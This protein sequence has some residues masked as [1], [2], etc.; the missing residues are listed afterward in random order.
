MHRRVE[1]WYY[2]RSSTVGLV[3]HRSGRFVLSLRYCTTLD[4]KSWKLEARPREEFGNA[5][6]DDGKG[7][8]DLRHTCGQ[9]TAI[10]RH[11]HG[12]ERNGYGK[13]SRRADCSRQ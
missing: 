4:G 3:R 6:A 2:A 12:T 10:P 5:A 9:P 1:E 11:A 13:A 8:G 7:L